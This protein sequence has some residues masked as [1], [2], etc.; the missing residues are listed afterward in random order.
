MV[1]LGTDRPYLWVDS[2]HVVNE[3]EI[4]AVQKMLDVVHVAFKANSESP[5]VVEFLAPLLL[6]KLGRY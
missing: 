4:E 1:G 6:L 2:Y 5:L 3:A